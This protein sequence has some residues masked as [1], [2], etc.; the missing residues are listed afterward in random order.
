MSISG[1]GNVSPATPDF[2]PSILM[3]RQAAS[4]HAAKE[5]SGASKATETS[6][7]EQ[8]ALISSGTELDYVTDLQQSEG[9]YKKT[10]DKTSKSPK[11]K[12]KG[13]FSKVR[14]GTK[15][16]LTGFGTRA[17]RISAR[18]AENNG[19]GMSMIPSRWNM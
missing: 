7:A 5:A 19:E 4:A 8:Q 13:N 12:L 2:D 11:T 1:S 9:K 18:K 15:G 3:G 10:L 17:S 14:A 6:A 16:F